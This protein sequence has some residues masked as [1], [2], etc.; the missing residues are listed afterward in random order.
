MISLHAL[1]IL[2]KH[3]TEFLG[4]NFEQ[5]CGSM[6][7]MVS[8]YAPILPTGNLCSDKWQAMTAVPYG[9]W[10]PGRVRFFTFPFHCSHELNRQIMQPS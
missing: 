2:K 4:I 5:V 7:L 8:C 9:R 10:T 6:A 1:S 3:I